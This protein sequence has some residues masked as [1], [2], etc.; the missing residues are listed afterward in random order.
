MILGKQEFAKA[1]NSAVFPGQQGGPLMHVIAGKAVAL[2][3]AGTPEFADRQR[4]TL[5]GAR[6]VA[7]RL[8]ASDVAKAGVSVVSGGT[9]VHLVLVDLRDSRSMARRPKTC[10]TRRESRSTATLSPT[11][12]GHRW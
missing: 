3:I 6:I 8:M 9:D 12:R 1:I 5:A 10:C 4:R 7:D 2:K 11:I